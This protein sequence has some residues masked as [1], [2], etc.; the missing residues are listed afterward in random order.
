MGYDNVLRDQPREI[1][2]RSA[3]RAETLER[4]LI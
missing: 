1:T 4:L 2:G 3:I